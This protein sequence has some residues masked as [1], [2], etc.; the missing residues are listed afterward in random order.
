MKCA[1]H[2]EEDAIA[3]CR[4]CGNALCSQCR[5]TIA[6][7]A[8]C[9]SCLDVGRIRPP[10]H[11]AA[12]P[13]DRLPIPLG[14]ISRMSRHY[15]V[16]GLV[17]MI[18]IAIFV[19]AQ[20]VF[21][22]FSFYPYGALNYA[23]FIPRTMGAVLVAIGIC[24][25]AFAWREFKEYFNFRWAAY[26][27]VFTLLTPWWG[28]A[29]DLLVYSG[30]VITQIPPYGY[31][32]AGP[33]TPLFTNL[34]LASNTFFGILMVLW[35]VALLQVRKNSRSQKLI[36]GASI[37]Y[38][39]L[40]HMTLIIIPIIVQSMLY[41]P[42]LVISIGYYSIIPAVLI[43]IGVILNAVFFYRLVASIKSY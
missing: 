12:E 26:I 40:A 4:S 5:V 39:I 7:I 25:S 32:G 10:T 6:G 21:T 17:G 35:A 28:L 23:V 13:E 9:Q 2:Q 42:Y 27:A 37:I 14:N 43:E 20:W 34:V 36:F 31:W 15:L 1:V 29:A 30:L 22:L 24:F 3:I 38:I 8:Y 11:L 18:L 16:L 41:S 19:H 33:L